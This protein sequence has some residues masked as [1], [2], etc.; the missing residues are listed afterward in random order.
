MPFSLGNTQH[1]SKLKAAG[2]K[3]TVYQNT[4]LSTTEEED[5]DKHAEDLLAPQHNAECHVLERRYDAHRHG[6]LDEHHELL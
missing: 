4:R 3:C 6:D 5:D 2:S 1:T